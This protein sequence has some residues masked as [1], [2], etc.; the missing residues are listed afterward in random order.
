MNRHGAAVPTVKLAEILEEFDERLGKRKEPDILTLTEKLGFVAQRERFNK[1][2]AVADTSDYKVIGVHDIAFN[3][4]LLWAAAIAQNTSWD[5]AIISPLYPTFHVRPAYDPRFVN[6]IL[7]SPAIRSHYDRISFGSIPRRRRAA[8]GDFLDISVPKPPSLP[9]QRR[10]ASILDTA[11]AIRRKRQHA[12][13]LTGDLLRST[14]LEM[15]GDPVRGF[16][17]A[18]MSTFGDELE[19]IQYGPRFNNQKYAKSGIRIVRITDLNAAGG[20]DFPSMPL[21]AVSEGERARFSLVPGDLIFARTGATVG[22][23]AVIRPGDPECIAGAYFIR[24]RFKD[25][26]RP[27]YAHMVLQSSPIQAHI[28]RTSRQ[29]AQQNFSGPAIKR[30]P[31]PVPAPHQQERLERIE[32]TIR[33]LVGRLSQAGLEA[34]SLFGS[35]SQQAFRGEL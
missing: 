1:R 8:V 29:A 6:Y 28:A 21:L 26:V 2:L 5:R 18:R 33:A 16:R 15:F 9:E 17:G 31:L 3:P 12:I 11:D 20:L 13:A 14:F 27:I 7:H 24:L 23:S 35:L 4:Y 19:S 32:A 10:I 22:K 30:L 25:G 34:E